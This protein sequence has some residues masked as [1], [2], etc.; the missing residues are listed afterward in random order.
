MG[1]IKRWVEGTD[2]KISILFPGD[3]EKKDWLESA[4]CWVIDLAVQ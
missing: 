1:S 4:A 2:A 3:K